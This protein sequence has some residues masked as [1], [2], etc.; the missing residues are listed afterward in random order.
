VFNQMLASLASAC[1]VVR[2]HVRPRDSVDSTGHHDG[3]D[4]SVLET[5]HMIGRS[6]I[7]GHKQ[8]AVDTVFEHDLDS[9]ALNL[10]GLTVM[11]EKQGST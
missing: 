8:H 7:C 11:T 9:L 2:A 4:S 10:K 5:L 3:R 6:A 1:H